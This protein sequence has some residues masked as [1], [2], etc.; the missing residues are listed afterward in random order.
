MMSKIFSGEPDRK[1]CG[2]C[3]LRSASLLRDGQTHTGSWRFSDITEE[4]SIF[5]LSTF[6]FLLFIF[7]HFVRIPSDSG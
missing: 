1:P 4:F 6:I 3:Q 5:S 7:P 2:E